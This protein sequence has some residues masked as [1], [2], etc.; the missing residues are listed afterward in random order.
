LKS[1][2]IRS[3]PIN[4]E[5]DPNNLTSSKTNIEFV[6]TEQASQEEVARKETRFI[7]PIN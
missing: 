4:I 6:V 7:A 3:F 5:I 2:E 1:N